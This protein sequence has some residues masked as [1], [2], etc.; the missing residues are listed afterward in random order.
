M[1]GSAP[2]SDPELIRKRS[3]SDPKNASHKAKNRPPSG[4]QMVK[5]EPPNNPKSASLTGFRGG[6][7]G[8][9]K[10]VIVSLPFFPS[11]ERLGP[12][13]GDLGGQ[14]A[15]KPGPTRAKIPPGSPINR[16]KPECSRKFQK[17]LNFL[18]INSSPHP[19][20][21]QEGTPKG[22]QTEP[23]SRQSPSRKPS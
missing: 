22:A 6:P 15:P 4:P 5:N 1:L 10:Y 23:K 12:G 2:E 8:S 14:L 3:D 18:Q 9:R 13:L 17:N 19:T 7:A 20:C 16:H 11:W 21:P